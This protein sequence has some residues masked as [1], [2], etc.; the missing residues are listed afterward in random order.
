[1]KSFYDVPTQVMYWDECEGTY[2]G[3]IAYHDE[4]ICAID[5]IVRKISNLVEDAKNSQCEQ[6]YVI[7]EYDDWMDLT[8]SLCG[9]ELP[10]WCPF[11]KTEN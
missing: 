4:V 1:M 9:G 2:V 7:Y 11:G 3:G 5:G 6:S 10:D 8:N